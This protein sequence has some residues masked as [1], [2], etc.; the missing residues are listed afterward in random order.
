MKKAAEERGRK[1]AGR[2]K[3]AGWKKVCPCKRIC[4]ESKGQ[5]AKE[6]NKKVVYSDGISRPSY[7]NVDSPSAEF[8][9]V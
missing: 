5:V 7:I 4:K 3:K 2:K 8:Q 9:P 6:G 1:R